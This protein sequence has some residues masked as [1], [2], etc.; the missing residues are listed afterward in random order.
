MATHLTQSGS[1]TLVNQYG[2]GKGRPIELDEEVITAYDDDG[3]YDQWTYTGDKMD[4]LKNIAALT[5]GRRDEKVAVWDGAS[6][7]DLEA[8]PSDLW[9]ENKFGDFEFNENYSKAVLAY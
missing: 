5:L 1:I 8:T 9:L 2:H 7:I 3:H 4:A 6:R